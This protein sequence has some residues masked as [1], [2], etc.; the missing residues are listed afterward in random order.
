MMS[1]RWLN[2]KRRMSLRIRLANVALWLCTATA[3]SHAA[4]SASFVNWENAPIHP[5][6]LSPDGQTLA[7][8]NL[9]DARLELFY[10]GGGSPLTIGNVP[11][12]LDPVSVRFRTNGEVWVTNFI[13]DSVSVVDIA[14]RRVVATINTRDEPSDVVFAGSPLRAFVSCSLPNTIQIIDPDSRAIVGE[15]LIDAEHPRSLAVSADGSEVYAAI[16]ESGNASTLI[17]GGAEDT[18]IQSFPPID[19]MRDVSGP[20]QSMNPPPNDGDSYNSF[21][22]P[23]NRA[24]WIDAQSGLTVSPPHVGQ[25]VKKNSAGRWMDDN[26]HEWTRYISGAD[27]P[28]SGRPPGWDLPD[29]DIAIIATST[30]A[31]RYASGLM[32]IC[33]SLS[34]NPASG[35]LALVGTDG[36]NEIRFE[37]ILQGRFNRVELGLVDPAALSKSVIDLN[38]HLAATNYAVSTIE[39]SER[40]KSIGDPRGIIWSPDGSRGY[41]TGMGSNN[42]VVIDASGNRVG[43]PIVLREGPTGMAYDRVFNRLY[44]LNR[45][46]A[47]ISVVDVNLG[48]E[49]QEVPFFDPTPRAIRT[50]RK[51]LYDTHKNS[52]LGQLACGSCHIDSRM[53]RLAW[54]LGDPSGTL[55]TVRAV[56]DGGNQNQGGNTLQLRLNFRDFHPMKGPMATQTLQDIIGHE[57]FHWRGDRDGIEEFNGAFM[58]LLG[59]DAQLT[60]HEMQEF[61]DFLATITF[62]PNPLRTI[63]NELPGSVDLTGHYSSGRFASAGGLP[64]GGQLPDG[65][66]RNGM[67]IYRNGINGSLIDTRAFNCVFCHTLPT[68]MGVDYSL[69]PE[70]EFPYYEPIPTGP[71]GEHHLALVSVDGSTNRTIKIPQIRNMLQKSGCDFTHTTSRAGFGFLHDGSIDSLS[72]FM[73]EGAFVV[74]NDQNV[75]DLV[76][77]GLCFSGSDLP[78]GSITELFNPPGP[79]SK[80]THAAVGKQIT[81]SGQSDSTSLSRLYTFL[82]LAEADPGR[83][84]LIARGVKDRENRGWFFDRESGKF[85]A[86]R[87]GETISFFE[88]QALAGPGTELTYT[89]VPRG[90]GR[91]MGIDR[92][93]DGYGDRTEI[94]FHSDPANPGSVPRNSVAAWRRYN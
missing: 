94:D 5:V 42:L 61:E 76:A 91:R 68:G 57:P 83:C 69:H 92:D 59:A 3:A 48:S 65:N 7:V 79:P 24:A 37:P 22:P 28:K 15:V 55:K 14:A 85:L 35:Q 93:E 62:P 13:S 89:V 31:V 82:D 45:F 41:V 87:D 77:F 10:V 75:A 9:P 27:A 6:D 58:T 40:D 20:Y 90:S 19:A 16:F 63:T 50:G 44:V 64:S 1:E 72:R 26:A 70:A 67:D 39:K 8:C 23:Q 84:D 2:G 88:L 49:I 86:D 60:A 80:D 74:Q 51:H 66:P 33:M 32:N 12:G 52:G 43:D 36:T 56:T 73:S 53:D 25:I 30:L 81:F 4:T 71:L 34:V 21:T 17:A 46:A 38:P 11:V 47:S 78:R 18:R 54:D 29:R